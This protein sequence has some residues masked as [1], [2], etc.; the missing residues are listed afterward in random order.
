MTVHVLNDENEQN[1][2]S[3]ENKTNQILQFLFHIQPHS[4]GGLV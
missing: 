3:T 1:D 2:T 4:H